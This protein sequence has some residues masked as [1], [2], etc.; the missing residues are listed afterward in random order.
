M[1]KQTK[2]TVKAKSTKNATVASKTKNAKVE[3]KAPVV[4]TKY[5]APSQRPNRNNT[6]KSTL[7]N[8]KYIF[9]GV[10]NPK[11]V[12]ADRG[13]DT[14]EVEAIAFPAERAQAIL[15]KALQRDDVINARLC[16]KKTPEGE[17][18]KFNGIWVAFVEDNGTVAKA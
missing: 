11:G 18:G 16:Y 8:R 1:T 7:G 9:R 15:A 10:T 5:G 12:V 17:E 13:A 14:S 6:E 2:K 4:R 3:A